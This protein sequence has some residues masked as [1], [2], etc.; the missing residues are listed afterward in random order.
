[1]TSRAT[2]NQRA[3]WPKTFDALTPEQERIRDDFMKRWLE[4]LPQRYGAIERFNHRYPIQAWARHGRSHEEGR[5]RTLEIGAGLGAHIGY[6]DLSHQDYHVLE[7]R[8][9]LVSVLRQ[10][11]PAVHAVLGNAEESM[12]FVD[13]YFHRIVIVHVLEHLC[14]LPR[15]LA[16]IDRVLGPSG[17]LCVVAPCEGSLAYSLARRISAQRIF[18]KTYRTPY[19]WFIE[20]EHVN[21]YDEVRNELA[22]RFRIVEEVRWP[23][24]GL[25]LAMNLVVGLTMVRRTRAGAAG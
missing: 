9:N 24:P 2:A 3:R 22:R 21:T 17:A 8:Q 23:L 20:R 25:P 6:E 14:N 12:P 18:E 1:V 16:E 4:V 13:Q 5:V 10:R 19:A 15:A 11:Y 7:M